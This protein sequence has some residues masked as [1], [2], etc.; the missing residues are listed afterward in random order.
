MVTKLIGLFLVPLYTRVL[1]PTDYGTLNLVN[2]TFYFVVVLAVFALDSA[3]ARWFYDT[4]D[5]D[6]RK[7][8]ISSWFWFQLA[9]SAILA[10]IIILLSPFISRF[11]LKED[12]PVLFIIP[13][14]GLLANI[15]PG[16]V[17]NWLRYQRKAVH[18]VVFTILNL[19]VNVGMN[20]LLVLV[21]K[22]GV[23]GILTAMLVSNTVASVYVM[24]LMR[25]WIRPRAFSMQRLKEM[26][27]FAMPLIPTSI[28]FWVMNS[29]SSFIIEH[30]HGKGEVGLYAIGSMLASAVTMVV[31]SFQMAWGPFAFSIINKPEAKNTYAM[32][33]TLYSMLM[34]SVAL[35]VAL[36]A[37]EGLM[38]LT[39]PAY[40]GASMV[41]GL[42]AFNAIIYGY[43]YIASI[44]T[45]IVK[46]NRPLALAV[47]M[48]ALLTGSLYFLLVPH[49][50]K[51]GAAISTS[52]GYLIVPA[53]I[54]YKA[55]QYW[56]IPYKFS[57]SMLVV[58]SALVC[59][60]F[61]LSVNIENTLIL[62]LVKGI[63]L[64][65]YLFTLYVLFR[66]NYPEVNMPWGRRI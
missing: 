6:D 43:A 18:M 34:S 11:I 37:R 63:I 35:G 29:S 15:L 51:E 59:F 44:G 50:G 9:A 4:E 27:R 16:M 3:S 58:L 40:H 41:A 54:F 10:L 61:S 36:F 30:Y 64:L 53:Y 19:L 66:K 55:Q 60:V 17:S 20:V 42:L 33:L 52:L 56:H 65:V 32:V 7:S 39:T 12:K 46:D 62:L 48:A 49:F 47:I 1:S 25:D 13:A 22:W 45:S 31:G 23:K 28:A 5:T 24:M 57:L 8:T 2:A 26:L 38:I 14:L 21:L